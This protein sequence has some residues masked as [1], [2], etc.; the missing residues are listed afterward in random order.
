VPSASLSDYERGTRIA[1]VAGCGVATVAGC[2][3]IAV[4][5]CGTVG[6]LG[7]V[8]G[9]V[10]AVVDRGVR[11]AG[12]PSAIGSPPSAGVGCPAPK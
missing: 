1:V 9:V 3:A 2:E 4:A 5:G 8:L 12:V 11:Y 6:S 10:A 7:V